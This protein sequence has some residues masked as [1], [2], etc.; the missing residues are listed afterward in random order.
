[1][2]S[3]LPKLSAVAR[4]KQKQASSEPSSEKTDPSDTSHSD[5]SGSSSSLASLTEKARAVRAKLSK[6]WAAARAIRVV[7]E[8]VKTAEALRAERDAEDGQF[9][10]CILELM[11]RSPGYHQYLSEDSVAQFWTEEEGRASREE[12]AARKRQKRGSKD[13]SRPRFS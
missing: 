10:D 13:Q 3:A 11:H 12:K 2:Q 1:M 9:C 7:K 5:S 4:G 6:W 8:P